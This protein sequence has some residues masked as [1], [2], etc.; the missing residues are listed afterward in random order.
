MPSNNTQNIY[1]QINPGNAVSL[2]S[3]AAGTQLL[4]PPGSPQVPQM[5]KA[6]GK[7]QFNFIR[8]AASGQL[9]T[10]DVVVI[11]QTVGD[12]TNPGRS[13]KDSP[14]APPNPPVYFLPAPAEGTPP[15]PDGSVPGG[16][17]NIRGNGTVGAPYKFSIVVLAV[18]ATQFLAVDPTVIINP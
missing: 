15:G 11:S 8:S 18:G 5:V 16:S 9:L 7:F 6:G 17:L 3:D 12:T 1:I 13:S 14:F 2:Y 4:N 10:G